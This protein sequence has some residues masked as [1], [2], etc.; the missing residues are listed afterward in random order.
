[1]DFHPAVCLHYPYNIGCWEQIAGIG[2]TQVITGEIEK[3]SLK[4][5]MI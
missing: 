1:M 3:V 4:Q 2:S 5:K